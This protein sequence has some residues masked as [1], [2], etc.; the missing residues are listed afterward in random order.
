M[1]WKFNQTEKYKTFLLFQEEVFLFAKSNI[2]RLLVV[3]LFW[4]WCGFFGLFWFDYFFLGRGGVFCFVLIFI[5]IS[6][7]FF[8][9]HFFSSPEW[10]NP[11]FFSVGHGFILQHS[12]Q[13]C[14]R[15]GSR[16]G[17]AESCGALP[18]ARPVPAIQ[19]DCQ[20]SGE[21]QLQNFKQ[22]MLNG[23]KRFFALLRNDLDNVLAVCFWRMEEGER[24]AET[25]LCVPVTCS[26]VDALGS[27]WGKLRCF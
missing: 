27:L 21:K 26:L 7:F 6:F 19:M 18:G 23:N 13:N 25:E 10:T 12:F 1:E 20:R 4:L 22:I 3:F 24:R 17:P 8:F 5:S 15:V 11:V 16:L 9:S 14:M 2:C